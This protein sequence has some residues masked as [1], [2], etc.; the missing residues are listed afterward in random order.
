MTE[1]THLR[2]GN[3]LL[4][5][6]AACALGI[7]GFGTGRLDDNF[8]VAVLVLRAGPDLVLA[9]VTAGIHAEAMAQAV[10][11][12]GDALVYDPLAPVVPGFGIGCD[13]NMVTALALIPVISVV[14]AGGVV[15]VNF[16]VVSERGERFGVG[17]AAVGAGKGHASVFGAGR[18]YPLALPG[19]VVFVAEFHG[20]VVAVFG[21]HGVVLIDG[22]RSEL[23]L[24]F[25]CDGDPVKDNGR[26]VMRGIL[27]R[28]NGLARAKRKE[29]GVGAVFLVGHAR[30]KLFAGPCE[31][32]GHFLQFGGRY[33]ADAEL[34]I[35][36]ELVAGQVRNIDLRIVYQVGRVVQTGRITADVIAAEANLREAQKSVGIRLGGVAACGAALVRALKD[37][38][39]AFRNER[40]GGLVSHVEPYCVLIGVQR[41]GAAGGLV[42]VKIV[43]ALP[44][45]QTRRRRAVVLDQI[46]VAVGAGLGLELGDH[47]T[48]IGR[49]AA[50]DPEGAD[51]D[52]QNALAEC[53]VVRNIPLLEAEIAVVVHNI[54]HAA[55]KIG[56]G[57]IHQFQTGGVI[58]DVRL[59]AVDGVGLL[60]LQC[61]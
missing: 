57:V 9:G 3:D 50:L 30:L 48:Q 59:D 5:A 21:D 38:L 52:I 11:S 56:V 55:F 34:V 18:L 26:G 54:R 47:G 6:A 60:Q 41:G 12:G 8:P 43:V 22:A 40:P 39:H 51:D 31:R 25:I 53:V 24:I 45:R 28:K 19:V 7:T 23:H 10:L 58:Q 49:A 46:R 15:A 42:G 1:R 32:Y 37:E 2:A 29:H 20:E 4:H 33:A 61:E 35:D 44:E 14:G 27:L 16:V 13:V 36:D 17:P